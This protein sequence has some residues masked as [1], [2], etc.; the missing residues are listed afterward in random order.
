MKEYYCR[1]VFYNKLSSYLR[2]TAEAVRPW[3]SYRL[4]GKSLSNGSHD[5]SE[6]SQL[7]PDYKHT[8]YQVS[9]ELFNAGN[10]SVSCHT[11]PVSCSAFSLLFPSLSP[12]FSTAPLKKCEKN[13]FWVFWVLLFLQA[14]ICFIPS[15]LWMS[16]FIEDFPWKVPFITNMP[17][18]S[19]SHLSRN[20]N[21]WHFAVLK[22]TL[23]LQL[24]CIIQQFPILLTISLVFNDTVNVINDHLYL[25][26]NAMCSSKELRQ[27]LKLK[28]ML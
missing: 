25:L 21:T 3:S 2:S 19:V 11:A 16:H 17:S 23:L 12:A 10:P 14:N 18:Y 27:T 6:N 24:I 5:G 15:H 22:C 26:L 20:F 7:E 1:E 13:P 9:S 8:W 28:F 4:E